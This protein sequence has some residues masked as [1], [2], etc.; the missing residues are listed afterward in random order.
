MA[1]AAAKRKK[2]CKV[3][4]WGKWQPVT[5]R[6]FGYQARVRQCKVC[7]RWQAQERRPEGWT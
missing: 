5:N 3:H 6:S 4:D 2:A 1:A 7:K